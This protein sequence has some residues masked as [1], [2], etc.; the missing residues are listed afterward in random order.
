[1]IATEGADYGLKLPGR[2]CCPDFWL[3]AEANSAAITNGALI[4]LI[5]SCWPA[6]QTF[7]DAMLISRDSSLSVAERRN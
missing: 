1:M 3:E 5:K 6:E 7:R 2:T 4:E